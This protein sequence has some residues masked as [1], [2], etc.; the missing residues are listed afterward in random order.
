MGQRGPEGI[1]EEG[2]LSWKIELSSATPE[3]FL[4]DRLVPLSDGEVL[5]A[6]KPFEILQGQKSLPGV[7]P[8]LTPICELDAENIPFD[9]PF[10]NLYGRYSGKLFFWGLNWEELE[11]KEG[12]FLIAVRA[13]RVK[14]EFNWNIGWV[15]EEEIG[16][17]FP[18]T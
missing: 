11:P 6:F 18:E 16:S 7:K 2:S 5:E 1:L 15:T 13:E 17:L 12:M 14:D 10:C 8:V 9:S 3:K 4:E